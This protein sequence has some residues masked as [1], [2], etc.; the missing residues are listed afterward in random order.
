M[1]AA[2]VLPPYTGA[3][4]SS[5]AHMS[6]YDTDLIELIRRFGRSPN[7]IAI[8]RGLLSYRGDL[9]AIG[10]CD[11]W[12]WLNGSF[13]EGIEMATGRSP[14]DIDIVTFAHLPGNSQT[15]RQL[16]LDNLDLFDAGRTR[17]RYRCDGYFV[18]LANHAE[19]LV[20]DTRYWFGLFSHQRATLLWKGMLKVSMADHDDRAALMLLNDMERQLGGGP[21]A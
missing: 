16:A 2:L 10:I 13:T 7:R 3:E 19:R 17:L 4:A 21:H 6:P 5:R 8:L 11:G 9:R 1:N 18:D 12:Q 20:D 14:A 15:K